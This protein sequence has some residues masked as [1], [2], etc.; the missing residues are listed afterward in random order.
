MNLLYLLLNF[1][2]RPEDELSMNRNDSILS[3]RL[4]SKI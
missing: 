1:N 3:C 2:M 4:I